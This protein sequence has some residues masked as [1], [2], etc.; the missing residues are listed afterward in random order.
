[1][2]LTIKLGKE[3]KIAGFE[4]PKGLHLEGVN[5]MTIDN[6]LLTVL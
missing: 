2:R 4:Y 5:L 6:G 1:V 3:A